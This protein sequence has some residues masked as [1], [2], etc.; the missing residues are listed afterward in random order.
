[1]FFQII[2]FLSIL[3]LSG[4]ALYGIHAYRKENRWKRKYELAEE[5]LGC[6][7]ELQVDIRMIRSPMGY[8][9]EGK[10]REKVENE[11]PEQTQILNK[12]YVV[13]ERYL[14][15]KRAFERLQALRF[16]FIAVFGKET[17]S[18]FTEFSNIIND[19][20]FA[21]DDLARFAIGEYGDYKLE[22]EEM[23]RLRKTVYSS[24]REEDEIEIKLSAIV[25]KMEATCRKILGG[26]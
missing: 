21:A 23:L 14:K 20:F 5:V 26:K 4:T 11:T 3:I 24:V 15:N 19:I 6:V 13:K 16:R 10:S 17:E 2:E 25:S 7:Y 22:K 12:F 18:S 9:G 1:M 8:V